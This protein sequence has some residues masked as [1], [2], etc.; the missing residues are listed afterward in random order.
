MRPE[1]I[2]RLDKIII[3]NPLS[4]SNILKIVKVRLEE[5]QTRL[6]EQKLGLIVDPKARRWLA[7]NGYNSQDGARPLRR[8]I[9]VEIEDLIAEGLLDGRFKAGDIIKIGLD[10]N[11]TLNAKTV[12]E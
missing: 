10:N 1:L 3:F 6:L 8:L 12:K 11:K 7:K 4:M 2:N 9:Q 5:L